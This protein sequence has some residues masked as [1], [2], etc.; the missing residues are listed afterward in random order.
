MPASFNTEALKAQAL[1]SRTYALKR[2]SEN[3]ILTDTTSTQVYNDTNQL[4]K[5]WGSDYQKYYSKIKKAVEATKGE[6]ITYDGKYIDALYH[7]TSNGNT[8]DAIN[9]WNKNYPYLKSVS[10]KWDINASSYA[11]TSN[12]TLDEF[13]KKLGININTETKIE[14]LD[15]TVGNRISK[16]KIGDRE[17]TGIKVRELLGLRSTDFSI[18]IEGDKVVI[19]IKGYGHGVGLSQY[20]ANGMAKEGYTYKEIIKHYYS[21][22]SIQK[23]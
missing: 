12:F 6:Y 18:K 21:G 10:S 7:S 14:I 8:E 2:I 3:K 20:G 1:A 11:R 16:I 4:K 19:D 13:S 23:K 9:V 15:K 22:V 17:F 5:K